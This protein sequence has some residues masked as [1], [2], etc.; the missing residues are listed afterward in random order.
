MGDLAENEQL[1]LVGMEEE[2]VE[3]PKLS[4]KHEEFC[5]LYVELGDG[6]AAYLIVFPNVKPS[7]AAVSACK[8]LKKESI[9]KYIYGFRQI[10]RKKLEAKVVSHHTRVLE[11]DRRV[12]LDKDGCAKNV[13]DIDA[14]AAKILEFEQVSTKNGIKTLL[15]VPTRLEA[16]KEIAKII[17]LYEDRNAEGGGE[18]GGGSELNDIERA[19]RILEIFSSAA[20]AGAGQAVA[21]ECSSMGAAAG[22]T[23]GSI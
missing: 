7:T 1:T 9:R 14:E 11:T 10:L 12:F 13:H 22:A 4:I 23:E 15:K 19:A 6:K 8:L 2:P 5:R 20:K 18:G 17:G 3:L 16:S 21:D